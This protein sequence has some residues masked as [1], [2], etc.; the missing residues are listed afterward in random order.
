MAGREGAMSCLGLHVPSA[1]STLRLTAEPEGQQGAELTACDEA[2]ACLITL[3]QAVQGPGQLGGLP[4]EAT[5]LKGALQQP[6]PGG[7]SELMSCNEATPQTPEGCQPCRRAACTTP[8]HMVPRLC[9]FVRE[10]R[11]LADRATHWIPAQSAPLFRSV[12]P[13][14][15]LLNSM[16]STSSAPVQ[17]SAALV[18]LPCF[19]CLGS[20]PSKHLEWHAPPCYSWEHSFIW[21][22]S[23]AVG[24]QV[25]AP[26]AGMQEQRSV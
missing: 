11:L 4:A 25:E 26:S 12:P 6:R 16:S 24:M 17:R 20:Q 21:P 18:Q 7:A 23:P 13:E 3:P 1:G 15:M 19:P 8:K 10:H 2:G 22:T 14:R 9:P 5:C